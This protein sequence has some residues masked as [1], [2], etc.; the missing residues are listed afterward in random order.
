[1]LERRSPLEGIDAPEPAG[2]SLSLRAR[3]VAGA[4]LTVGWDS[5]AVDAQAAVAASS[6]GLKQA[7]AVCRAQ[8]TRSTLLA[9]LSPLRH[10]AV[11]TSSREAAALAQALDPAQSVDWRCAR[12]WLQ[13][14]GAAARAL[15]DAEVPVDLRASAFPTGTVVQSVLGQMDVLIH[16]AAVTDVEPAFDLLVGRS[17][18]RHLAEYLSDAA[19]VDDLT[20]SVSAA[21]LKS[22]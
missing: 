18:A 7:P 8:H 21:A 3:A 20:L 14:S 5:A 9:R 17:F 22:A 10:L 16:A 1:M 6:L 12:A 2:T 11:T 15:L 4:W 13:L 19:R